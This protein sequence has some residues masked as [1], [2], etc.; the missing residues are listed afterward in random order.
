M[1]GPQM[2]PQAAN[3][4]L[5]LLRRR[6]KVS[7]SVSARRGIPQPLSYLNVANAAVMLLVAGGFVFS[8]ALQH[9]RR[10]PVP[11]QRAGREHAA[12]RAP[13]LFRQCFAAE[14]GLGL[15]RVARGRIAGG[16]GPGARARGRAAVP[17]RGRGPHVRL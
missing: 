13:D 2:H 6:R 10:V 5:S 9:C 3:E 15:H 12:A 11:R 4:P 17:A 1:N 8:V 14:R 7:S 16:V